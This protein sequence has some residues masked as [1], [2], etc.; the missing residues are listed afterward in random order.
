MNADQPSDAGGARGDG[1]PARP[2]AAEGSRP[3]FSLTLDEM[4]AARDERER[5]SETW[6]EG[7]G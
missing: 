7:R 5:R 1:W 3:L 6:P 4:Y 2:A